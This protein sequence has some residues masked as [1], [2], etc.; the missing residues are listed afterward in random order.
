MATETTSP[1]EQAKRVWTIGSYS[2]IAPNFLSMAAHLVDAA[3]VNANDRVL[4]VGCGT[5]S[6]AI[7]AARQ[8]AR[9]TG[10]DIT[11]AMLADARENAALADVDIDW[12]EGSATDLPF[13]DDTFDVTLS[14]VGHVFADPPDAAARE[15]CRVTR[16]G[17]RIGFTSW[18]PASVVPA[19]GKV[20]TGYLPAERDA[21]D[22]HFLWGDPDVV[23]ERLGDGVDE[24]DFQTGTVLSPVLSPAHY[25]EAAT[26]QSGMFIVALEAVAEGDRSALREEM[27][28]AIEPYFDD[29]HNAV[30]MEYR[31]TRATGS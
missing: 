12:R 9:V 23:T 31:L 30:R 26:T 18:T 3:G 4:D 5:G 22:P 7:T 2:D 10:L 17:G 29:D 19:M 25:L 8:G 13:E 16:P 1:A 24:L 20:L 14:S 6:V 11:P 27:I 21:P 28:E 15:L